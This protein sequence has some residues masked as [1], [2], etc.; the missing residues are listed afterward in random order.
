[1]RQRL[2]ISD[3]EAQTKIRAK[4]LRALEAE[5]FDLLPGPTFVKT[6]LR[7]YA[8]VLGLDAR[9]LTEEYKLRYE[10]LSEHDLHPIAPQSARARQR[11]EKKQSSTIR[12]DVL[13]AVFIVALVGLLILLGRGGGGDDKT[14]AGTNTVGT[15]PGTGATT[16]P[17][18]TTTTKT[19]TTK[20]P[21]SSSGGATQARL[22]LDATGDVY[23][24]LKSGDK[25]LIKEQTLNADS[26]AKTYRGKKLR[27]LLGNSAVT[28]TVNGKK[29]TV[30][31]SSDPIAYVIT[32]KGR[33][34]VS[35]E[36]A[37]SFCS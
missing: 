17:A 1:M 6:F 33:T 10:R 34:K 24:C 18:E 31:A 29:Q 26:P 5:E 35:A 3:I 11:Q 14:A 30:P 9:L 20:K 27:L 22:R 2:D 25:V 19:A 28:M 15:T 4:Y 36:P 7:T 23:V 13:I 21:S 37:S 32:P 8:E 12:R 16:A